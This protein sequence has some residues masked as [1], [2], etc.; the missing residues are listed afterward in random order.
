[1]I[2]FLF[3]MLAAQCYVMW[4]LWQLLPLPVGFKIVAMLAVVAL[5]ALFVFALSPRVDKMPMPVATAIYEVGT[6]F[7]I[8]LFYLFV[9]FL[10]MEAGRLLHLYPRE[11][12][13]DSVEGTVFVFIVVTALLIYG[14]INYRHKR[15][16]RLELQTSRARLRSASPVRMVMASDLHL[17]YH[18]RRGELAR[19]VDSINAERPDIVLLAGDIVDRSV[20]PLVDDSMAIELRRIKAPVFACLGNHEY[21]AGVDSCMHFFREAGIRLLRDE[22]VEWGGMLIVGRD[23]RTNRHRKSLQQLMQ[24]KSQFSTF[25][26]QLP[27]IVLDH[28][29]YNLEESEQ[30]GVS[31]QLSGHTHHGQVWPASWL[32]DFLYECAH[33]PYQRGE[34]QYYVSSGLGI[35]GGKFRIGTT[36]EY[37]V[38]ELWTQ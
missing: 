3:F 17:G 22:A 33:G 28:Q 26:F 25:N 34:T 12:M 4:R 29:P 36:S 1:M 35:W 2:Y 30:C 10:L 9:L 37:V 6:S 20:R 8:V 24:D 7:V 31:F 5:L 16:V 21:Y 32:T 13:H 14:N 15:V 18:N 38:A 23:D 11:F 19:W 27:T